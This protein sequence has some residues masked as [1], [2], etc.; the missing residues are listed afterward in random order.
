MSKEKKSSRPLHNRRQVLIK[1]VA[2]AFGLAALGRTATALAAAVD[3][4]PGV[5]EG[6]YWVDELIDRSDVRS[7]PTTGV[8]QSGLPMSLAVNVAQL[9]SD[10]STSPLVGAYVDIWHCNA[11][12]IYSDIAAENT[13]GEKFLR[14]YQIT[15]A[16][17][18]VEF[19]TIYP[20]WYSG[21]TV[22]IHA[23]VRVYNAATDSVIYNFTTQFFFDDSITNDVYANI[24]PYT[25]RPNRDT[26]NSTDSVYTGASFDGTPSSNAGADL[27]LTLTE[28]RTSA[29]GLFNIVLNLSDTSNE[30]SS[31]TSGGG[32]GSG[33]GGTTSGGSGGTTS[34][35]SGGTKS[36]SGGTKK[37]SGGKHSHPTKT[38]RGK[39]KS[40]G[41]TT[42][43]GSSSTSKSKAKSIRHK[44][45]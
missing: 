25:E 42:G 45:A 37:G 28:D 20:G 24:S 5:T 38:P 18:N 10:G 33:S 41:S 29:T 36:G 19:T 44:R 32:S 35:G 13:L 39:S 17:G 43:S 4:T 8:V 27:L 21:R 9:N 16:S 11:L 12:G 7:D 22:H 31:G 26:T 15:D 23:R 3:E 2:G 1:G 34:G 30:G 6:P 40:S 14:G